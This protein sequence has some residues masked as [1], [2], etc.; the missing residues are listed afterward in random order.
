MSTG[1]MPGGTGRESSSCNSRRTCRRSR[2]GKLRS[3]KRHVSTTATLEPGVTNNRHD[4]APGKRTPHRT[5]VMRNS[6]QRSTTSR[7]SH[8]NGSRA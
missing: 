3:T 7:R 6:V 5:A 8:T 4:P 2:N 1:S